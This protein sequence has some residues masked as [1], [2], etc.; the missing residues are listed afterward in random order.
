MRVPRYFQYSMIP[1]TLDREAL[2]IRRFQIRLSRWGCKNRPFFH[3]IV[4]KTSLP[5]RKRWE[6]IEQVGTLDPFANEN[7]EK[8]VSLNI[9]RLNHYIAHGVLL[10][11]PVVMLLG[12]AGLLPQHP[13]S[14]RMAWRNRHE[15]KAQKRLNELETLLGGNE[16]EKEE[17]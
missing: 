6:T 11:T 8:L 14:Y 7:G 4:T 5:V 2:G 3:L 12:M 17:A 10:S 16:S 13:S 1:V 15:L 9:E